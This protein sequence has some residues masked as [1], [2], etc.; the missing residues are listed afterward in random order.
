MIKMLKDIA[1]KKSQFTVINLMEKIQRY[2]FLSR[3]CII[4]FL[5][6][7]ILNWNEDP[8]SFFWLSNW[9]TN[10]ICKEITAASPLISI[11]LYFILSGLAKVWIMITAEPQNYVIVL[12]ILLNLILFQLIELYNISKKLKFYIFFI[13][14]CLELS[15]NVCIVTI[16]LL[17]FFIFFEFTLLFFF[18]LIYEYGSRSRKEYATQLLLVY[19]VFGSLPLLI[20]IIKIYQIFN[21]WYIPTILASINTLS[22][23]TYE[24][25]LIIF[26]LFFG[27]AVK[28]PIFPLHLWLLEA[29][30]EAST[31][32][33]V[34]LAGIILKLGGL[35]MYKFLVPFS[36]E[37]ISTFLHNTLITILF[38]G[39]I[40]VSFSIFFQNDIK[41]IIAYSSV[42]HM[43]F[44]LLAFLTLSIDGVNSFIITMFSHGLTSGGLFFIV[45]M[46]YDRYGSRNNNLF[47]SLTTLNPRLIIL[48]F[49]LLLSNAGFPLTINFVGELVGLIALFKY[50][51]LLCF[52]TLILLST[53]AVFNFWLITKLLFGPQVLTKLKVLPRVNDLKRNEQLILLIL[54]ILILFF[55]TFQATGLI[56]MLTLVN[57]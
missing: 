21:T 55:G 26:L 18:L 25:N 41:R 42:I 9:E 6:F 19:T 20:S 32:T 4:I 48:L 8:Y 46:L 37:L 34:L 28:V 5:F 36:L 16:N 56:S 11:V 14:I 2:I 53:T 10:S 35:G 23:E 50:S 22:I 24:S 44:S 7:I 57:S 27:F 38:I 29:H 45:G 12:F 17:V 15:I 33:S 13:L 54:V 30:V 49:L 52:F 39:L 43:I 40:I 47:N 1:N 31:I 51:K 3:L